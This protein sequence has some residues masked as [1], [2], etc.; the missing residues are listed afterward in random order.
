MLQKKEG[1]LSLLVGIDVY[2]SQGRLFMTQCKRGAERESTSV[3]MRESAR[4]SFLL[5]MLSAR[6]IDT[7]FLSFG[8][9]VSIQLISEC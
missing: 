4:I 5:W 2:V 1:A 3:C 6:E 8:G 7:N 9:N